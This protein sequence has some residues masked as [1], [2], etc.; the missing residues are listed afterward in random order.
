MLVPC[1][2][3][4]PRGRCGQFCVL[5]W[6]GGAIEQICKFSS[7]LYSPGQTC[8]PEFYLSILRRSKRVVKQRR[9]N[10]EETKQKNSSCL[11]R[12]AGWGQKYNRVQRICKGWRLYFI[13]TAQKQNSGSS[14]LLMSTMKRQTRQ[15]LTSQERASEKHKTY[16]SVCQLIQRNNH[17]LFLRDVPVTAPLRAVH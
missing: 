13:P 11:F 3:D 14:A 17:L 10:K 4:L 1:L 2:Y 5:A 16:N 8:L 7:L 9:K 12:T 6:V 15:Q